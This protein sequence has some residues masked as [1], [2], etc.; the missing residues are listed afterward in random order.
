MPVATIPLPNWLPDFV[1]AVARQRLNKQ[2]VL[3]AVPVEEFLKLRLRLATTVSSDDYGRWVQ[4]FL[5]DRSARSISPSSPI[6]L[7]EYV[8]RCTQQGRP[9]SL[10]EAV[11]LCPTNGLALARLARAWSLP[12]LDQLAEADFLS[13]RAMELAPDSP[14]VRQIRAWFEQQPK[15]LP[16]R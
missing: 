16:K 10:R 14:E 4:W 8:Q 11:S 15:R 13:R 7:P 12:Q 6:T 3:E 9:G 1:E 5:A 2:G